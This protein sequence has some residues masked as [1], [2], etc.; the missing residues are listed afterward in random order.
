MDMQ[1]KMVQMKEA[2]ISADKKVNEFEQ[3]VKVNA[4]ADKVELTRQEANGY[5]HIMLRSII[6][7]QHEMQEEITKLIYKQ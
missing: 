3:A 6:E 5:F 1:K 2:L 7:I 4:D